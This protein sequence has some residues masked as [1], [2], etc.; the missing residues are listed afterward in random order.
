[1][2]ATLHWGTMRTAIF[3][4]D[5]TLADTSG[6]LIEAANQCL[7]SLGYEAPLDPAL[8]Q[9]TAFQ[10]GRALLRLGI[11]RVTGERADETFVDAQ[12]PHLLEA[13]GNAIDRFTSVYPGVENALDK[14]RIDG[15]RLGICTNKPEGLSRILL[16]RLKLAE[17]FH[18]IVG[19]DTLPV[20]K[21]HPAPYTR[22][23]EIAEGNLELSFLVGDTVTDRDTA[24]AVGVPIVLA[25]FYLTVSE[26]KRLQPDAVLE[27]FDALPDL[28]ERLI[29]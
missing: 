8:D 29:G 5:G 12:Y 15:W 23:V 9:A 13:Y 10:G 6:D 11:S 28:A 25:A 16:E 14:L 18:S 21:P 17:Y 1:M 7:R 3:D 4:L 20:S 27:H 19:A 26:V 24:R 22:A 2:R